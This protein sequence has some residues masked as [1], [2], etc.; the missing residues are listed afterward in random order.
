MLLSLNR[1]FASLLLS[2]FFYSISTCVPV[3]IFISHVLYVS[4]HVLS[5]TSE[6]YSFDDDMSMYLHT[7]SGYLLFV[8]FV[9]LLTFCLDSI[10]PE[11]VLFYLTLT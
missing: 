3:D 6:K 2:D 8:G 5:E 1:D 11:I 9:C 7:V 4:V 10:K